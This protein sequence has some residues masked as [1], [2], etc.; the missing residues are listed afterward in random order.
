MT[1]KDHHRFSRVGVGL[2]DPAR[3][4]HGGDNDGG[5]LTRFVG[6]VGLLV[7]ITW[8]A[9]LMGWLSVAGGMADDLAVS[10]RP[11]AQKARWT[12]SWWMPRHQ[13]KVA[14]LHRGAVDLLMIG[15]SITQGWE[16]A[17][18]D[19]WRRYY[20]H[21]RAVNLGFKGDCT[22]H[23]LWRLINGEL[24]G[25][26]PRLAVVMIGTNNSGHGRQPKDTAEGI[27]RIVQELRQR[28]PQTKILLL[29]IFPVG[30]TPDNPIRQANRQVNR[31]IADFDDGQSVYFRN[32]NGV[33]LG[34]RGH[35][36]RAVM[37]DWLHPNA[38]GYRR[39]ALGMEPIVSR[40]MGDQALTPE[41][42]RWP[43]AT[44]P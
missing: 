18:A 20:R 26:A 7:M 41:S 25:I 36:S 44:L 8:A 30:P 2:N 40:L 1:P 28:L 37:P 39:W 29:A 22:E 9:A 6:G 10:A 19:V 38:E 23:V 27:K 24:E 3:L 16:T 31:I 11:V 35:L 32:I 14:R 43:T 13:A 17:G 12:Q 21:R 42:G 5:R 33:F 4:A 15:D 34:T